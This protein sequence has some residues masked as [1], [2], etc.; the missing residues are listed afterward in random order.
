MI[1]RVTPSSPLIPGMLWYILLLMT[2]ERVAEAQDRRMRAHRLG[3]GDRVQLNGRLD[4][5]FWRLAEPA[6]DFLQ[7]FPVEGQRSSEPSEVFVVYDSDHLY[8]GAMLH[9]SEPDG[10]IGHQLQRDASLASDDRFMWILDTFHDGRTGYFFE[11]NPAGLMGDGLL[12]TGGVNKAWDGIWEARVYRGEHGWSA[13]IRIPFRTLNFNP[14]ND[15]WGINFQRTIRRQN[16]ETLWNG[17]RRNQSLFEAVFAGDLTELREMSHGAG[18]EIKPY[19]VGGWRYVPAQDRPTRYS[20]DFGVDLTY[21]ITPS[22]RGALSIN[23]DFA[24]VEVDQRRVNLTR[25][26]LVFPEKRDFFLEG[27]N[28]FEFAPRN[29]ANLFFSRRIGLDGGQQIPIVAGARVAGQQGRFDIGVL[30]VRTARADAL[31]AEDFSVARVKRNFGEQ[32][33]LGVMATR[34]ASDRFEGAAFAPDRYS[35]GAD[36]ELTTRRFLGL[37]KNFNFQAFWAWHNDNVFADTSSGLDRSVRGLRFRYANDPVVFQ[38]SFRQ[39]GSVYNPAVGF[40]T[41]NNFKRL[42]PQVE[43]QPLMRRSAAIRNLRFQVAYETIWSLQ[44]AVLTRGLSAEVFG[45][46]LES[47]DEFALTYER[48]REVLERDFTIYQDLTIVAETYDFQTIGFQVESASRRDVSVAGGASYGSFWTGTRG[49]VAGALTVRPRAGMSTTLSWEHNDVDLDEG[50]FITNLYEFTL[51]WQFS[52]WTSLTAI[53]QYDDVSERLTLF[54][55]FRWTIRPGNDL[56]FLFT[57]N[58]ENEFVQTP[59]ANRFMLRAFETGAA[60]KVNYTHRL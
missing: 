49:S 1:R 24:E 15:T 46:E 33:S 10:V 3:E 16:E 55:R 52:P 5:P 8:I 28:L 59:N 34:R 26:P 44:N 27:S 7:R 60:F 56:F 35:L 31:P 18:L 25:F 22:L 11:I 36:L 4:E 57:R 30:Q 38:T 51:G 20:G 12:I 54:T 40:V 45:M 53:T 13:E 2:F 23:T 47:G 14:D 42:E 32:S 17:H 29:A 9:D 41:R 37:D 21:S 39:F 50:A 58:W 6:T 48:A 19:G 43:Y